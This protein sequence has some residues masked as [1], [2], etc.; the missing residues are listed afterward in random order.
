MKQKLN[1]LLREIRINQMNLSGGQVDFILDQLLGSMTDGEFETEISLKLRFFFDIDGKP[2][3]Q[4][5]IPA[6]PPSPSIYVG[7]EFELPWLGDDGVPLLADESPAAFPVKHK[8]E[9]ITSLNQKITLFNVLLSFPIMCIYGLYDQIKYEYLK[10]E[11]IDCDDKKQRNTIR[12]KIQERNENNLFRATLGQIRT[13]MGRPRKTADQIEATKTDFL[14]RIYSGFF[15]W[16][17]DQQFRKNNAKVKKSPTQNAIS[18]YVA[19]PRASAV[20]K[21]LSESLKI[22][23]FDFKL[24]WKIFLQSEN[25]DDFLNRVTTT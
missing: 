2:F 16:R 14:R 23:Q 22:Y 10:N 21:K 19:F 13:D 6:I 24:L 9:P 15:Q 7:D 3:I 1:E 25:A 20:E 12:K 5:L 8:T 11:F 17:L 4:A 18:R